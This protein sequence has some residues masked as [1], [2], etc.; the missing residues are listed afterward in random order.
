MSADMIAATLWIPE[1]KN[2]DWQAAEEALAQFTCPEDGF[3]AD[4]PLSGHWLEDEIVDEYTD[5]EAKTN[6]ERK[7]IVDG[8]LSGALKVIRQAVE[9]HRRDTTYVIYAGWIVYITGGFSNGDVPTDTAEA[10]YKIGETGLLEA[11]GFFKKP[12]KVMAVVLESEHDTTVTLV[13]DEKAAEQVVADFCRQFW[14][15]W[16]VDFADD[17][18]PPAENSEVIEQFFAAAPSHWWETRRWV[19]TE[20]VAL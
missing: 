4:S 9:G 17:P 19:S 6:R 3:P 7:A 20:K 2:P 13:P 16:V 15:R 1:N 8:I 14:D 5:K 10:I 12:D 18:K 11:A